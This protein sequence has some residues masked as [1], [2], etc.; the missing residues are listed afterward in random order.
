[1]P[2]PLYPPEL[3]TLTLLPEASL[4]RL[5]AAHAGAPGLEQL[6][7][8]LS[9]A[10]E[11]LPPG[12]VES[13]E[14]IT[15]MADE[16]GHQLLVDALGPLFAADGLGPHEL[17]AMAYLE[18]RELFDRVLHRRRFGRRGH[19][20]EYAGRE[21]FRLAQ[22]TARQ[23]RNLER[24]LGI[25]FE[26]RG[27][28]NHCRIFTYA[29]DDAVVF[30]I[31]HGRPK[32]NR[33]VVETAGDGQTYADRLTFRPHQVDVVV[34]DNRTHRIRICAP[35]A[36][37]VRI[38]L[39][40]ISAELFGQLGWFVTGDVVCLQPLIELGRD[41]LARTAGIEQVD[42]VSLQLRF[43]DPAQTKCIVES[44]C[45]FSSLDDI[46]LGR[47]DG[48]P[49]RARLRIAY[50]GGGRPRSLTL[51]VPNR[52]VYDRSRDE[53]VTRH[54]LEQRGFLASDAD[55]LRAVG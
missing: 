7:D 6:R 40:V 5:L 19:F 2:T 38:Y 32:Q 33:R 47:H 14:R 10:P 54:F 21:P 9:H 20:Q 4:L 30:E 43:P 28:S 45:V 29:Y 11:S 12:L 39:Q 22:P 41:A 26:K 36:L 49:V 55:D 34:Y 52:L 15:T 8:R 53:Q 42:L 35:N 27:A 3:D 50:T 48:T 46:R 23:V 25:R 16:D 44:P 17:A 1:M 13:I 18:K 24:A 37:T 31:G 51:G